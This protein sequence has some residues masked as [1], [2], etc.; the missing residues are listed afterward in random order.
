V[1]QRAARTAIVAMGQIFTTSPLIG[2][3]AR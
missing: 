1:T 2:S 3:L